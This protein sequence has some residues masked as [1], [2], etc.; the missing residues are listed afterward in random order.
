M[1]LKVLIYAQDKRGLGHVRRA[2]LIAQAL[3]DARPDVAVL[4]ATKSAWPTSMHLGSRFDFIKLP[5]E[6]TLKAAADHERD[7]ERA[8][9][10]ALR[11]DMLRDIVFRLA[12][13]LVLADTEP[14][15][16]DGELAPALRGC[17]AKLVYGMRDVLDQPDAIARRWAKDGA[18]AALRDRFS[19]IVIYGHPELFDSLATYGLPDAVRA[20]ATYAGYVCA[21]PDGTDP[22][23]TRA[24][25]GVGDEPFV[26][27]TG[28]G[29]VDLAP[30]L[31]A[32]IEAHPLLQTRP[33]PRLVLVTGPIMKPGDRAHVEE[34]GSAAGHIVRTQIDVMAAM[35]QSSALLTMG[36][37]NTL[38]EAMV[39]GRRPV[40]VPRATHK[41]EQI[42]R[43]QAFAARGLVQCLPPAELTG[44]TLAAALDAELA[45]PTSID[46]RAYLD[47]NGRRTAEALLE[48][49]GR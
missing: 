23:A 44:R 16:K 20:K 32:A 6:L 10:R 19:R 17:G 28:G 47:L 7:A 3:L 30:V 27:V 41:R 15:G 26:L 13:A 5:A 22:T 29:G 18:L 40:V 43:A 11:R 37:Y 24:E 9:I 46:A 42:I 34:L 36:G 1:P 31:H 2:M 45:E 8:A 14:L 39:V 35:A 12:P 49:V 4:L 33:R 48:V 38:V 21:P 25:L